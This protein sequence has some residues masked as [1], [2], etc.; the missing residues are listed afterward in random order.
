MKCRID[1][2]WEKYG[3]EWMYCVIL[4]IGRTEYKGNTRYRNYTTAERAAKRA[5][6]EKLN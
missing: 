6:N 1:C 5:L 2:V 4:I 3:E